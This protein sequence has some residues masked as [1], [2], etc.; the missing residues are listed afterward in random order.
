MVLSAMTFTME[1]RKYIF[2]LNRMAT[3]SLEPVLNKI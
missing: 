3:H 1:I 2:A